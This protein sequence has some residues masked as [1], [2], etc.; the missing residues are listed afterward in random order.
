M[1]VV[2]AAS[3]AIAVFAFVVVGFITF[4]VAKSELFMLVSTVAI[5]SCFCGR[6]FDT[7]CFLFFV[8]Q[9][10]NE[11]AKMRE[12]EIVVSIINS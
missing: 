9:R 8:K 4:L 7:F 5:I 12:T 6:F 2:I 3:V 11:I 10:N 1:F